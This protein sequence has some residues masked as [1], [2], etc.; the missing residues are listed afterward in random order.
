[1]K[2]L[3]TNTYAFAGET[4]SHACPEPIGRLVGSM[5]GTEDRCS[6]NFD[7]NYTKRKEISAR[8]FLQFKMQPSRE[9]AYV[10][11]HE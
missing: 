5:G 11:R 2:R 6:V 9:K 4:K 8:A 7:L 1:M 10:S 3:A